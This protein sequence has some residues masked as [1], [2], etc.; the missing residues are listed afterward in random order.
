[1][2]AKDFITIKARGVRKAVLPGFDGAPLDLVGRLIVKGLFRRGVAVTRA[3]SIAF[4]LLMAL[5]PAS[6]FMFTLI[7]FIP[8]PNFQTEL[9]RMFENILPANAY[10]FLET[11]IVDVIT[12]RSGTLMV[13]MFIATIIFSTNGIH[14]LM[15]AFV[16]S[17]HEFQSRT[18]I[19]QRKIA[20]VLLLIILLMFSISGALIILSRSVVNRLV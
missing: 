19:Q 20:V 2:T 12:N 10:S 3:S 16:V 8:I 9:V 13:V 5:L 18:W 7:P 14:A 4:N 6:I 17:A 11:T 15:H 1:M